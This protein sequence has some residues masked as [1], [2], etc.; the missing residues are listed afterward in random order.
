[1]LTSSVAGASLATFSIAIV[2]VISSLVLRR[3]I[4]NLYFHPLSKFPGPWYAASTSLIPALI[5]LRRIEPEWLLGLTKKYGTEKPIRIAPTMLL[6]P[7]PADMK[8]IYWDPSCNTKAEL[9][10]TGALG[11]PSLFTT[12]DGERHR[13]LRKALGGSQWTIGSL[14]NK[15]EPRM[16]ELISLFIE[17][18]AEFSERQEE[19]V[20]CDKVA[21]FA[22]DV[23]TMMA[24]SDPWGFVRNQR[25]ER[26]FLRSWREGLNYF[27]LAGRWKS[28][29]D[30]ILKSPTLAPYFLPSISD[31]YGM[32]Y[33]AFHADRQVTEREKMMDDANGAWSMENPDLM[34]YCLD[35][36]YADGSPLTPVEK[37]AHVTLLIQAG[38]DT[39]GT[40]MGSTLRFLLTHPTAWGTVHQEIAAADTARKLS[41]PIRYEESRQHLPYLTACVK[42]SIRL[43]P[44]ATNLF[45]RVAPPQGK[46]VGGVFVPGGA[47]ITAN[48]YVVHRDPR[49][50]APD[51]EAF[52][53]ERWLEPGAE[54]EMDGANFAFGIGPRTCLGKEVA[55]MEMW[56]LLP[57]IVR[58]FDMRLLAAGEYI[59]A[60]GVA[61]NEGLR[62]VPVRRVVT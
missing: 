50:Y 32:G 5:S 26:A 12:L 27:G 61:F 14:K 3:V 16:D 36:R 30:Y 49:L 55:Y 51:P 33:L 56:K 59:V 37:R 38:A 34:Q 62:V 35:A 21:E 58:N 29:R 45:A 22:A 43:N 42:E 31:T 28:Y 24:F 17:K 52:R 2:V 13:T 15:W 8:D 44:P 60:G 10:G 19:I 11:P 57:E 39:T 7:R 18:M 53:P 6:F 25:D 9:H 4:Y 20:L 1:M 46:A 54:G 41:R 23:L 40:A 47:E 48:A